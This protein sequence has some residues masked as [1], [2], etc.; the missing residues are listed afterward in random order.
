M[1]QEGTYEQPLL[2]LP[3]SS[4]LRSL[5]DEHDV[6]VDHCCV[7]GSVCL[8]VRGL[9]DHGDV[10]VC[11]APSVR[12][13]TIIESAQFELAHNR[14]EHLGISDKA[15][16][17][18]EEYHDVIDG[19]KVLRPEIEYSHK[20]VRQWD[21]DLDDLVL[22]DQYRAESDDWDP[23]LVVDDYTPGA[24]HLLRR[25]IHSLRRDGVRTT[26]GHGLTLL[27]WHGPFDRSS[28]QYNGQPTSI[29]GKALRSYRQDGIRKTMGR[30]LRLVKLKEP[31]GLVDRY[32]N[33]RHKIKVGTLV[34]RSLA[35]HY[36]VAELLDAQ[37]DG[38]SFTR[39]DLVVRLLAAE[40]VLEDKSTPAVVEWFEAETGTLIRTELDSLIQAEKGITDD[41]PVPIRYDSAILDANA[42]A[43]KLATGQDPIQVEVTAGTEDESYT[44]EWFESADFDGKETLE[45]RFSDLLY[46]SGALFPVVLWP[47]AVGY[48]DEILDQLREEKRIH[49]VEELQLTDS[50][51]EQFVWEMYESQTEINPAHIETKIEEMQEYEKVVRVAGIE[52]PDPRIREG[53]SN[54]MIQVKER[55]RERFTPQILADNPSANLVIHATDN[56]QHNRETWT[57][58]DRHRTKRRSAVGTTQR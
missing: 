12:D 19:I 45:R 47:T 50:E 48:F 49:L 13:N 14:Y 52:V 16:L 18:D 7:V 26:L 15:I 2:A 1:A 8:S 29:P 39:M 54:E 30:G 6:P 43:V 22:L 55:I 32:S 44:R 53:Y 25:G 21:K 51:F 28:P 38:D 3:F 35:V 40:A 9:R 20:R 5:L 23:H 46:E 37:Y 42:L 17:F 10:D 58:I 33:P 4:D 24:K 36:P 56:F 27:R 57:I 34:D 11:L 41:S 31:T